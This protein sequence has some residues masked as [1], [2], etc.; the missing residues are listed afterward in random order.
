MS[1]LTR[2]DFIR[3][4]GAGAA[5]GLFGPSVLAARPGA[6]HVVILGGGIGGTTAAKYIRIM[7]PDVKIALVEQNREYITCPRSN[8]VV[9]GYLELVETFVERDVPLIGFVKN[10]AART[11]TRAVRRGEGNAPWVNDAAFFKQVLERRDDDGERRTD[12]LTFTSWFVSR[13]GA[14]RVLSA[15]GD[16]LGLDRELDPELYEVTF[17][18][19]YDPRDD[20][21]FRVEAPYAFTRDAD[22]RERIVRQALQG[23]AIER[24]PPPAI[25]R[26]DELA[27]IDREE[28]SALG[29]AIERALDTERESGYDE[30]RWGVDYLEG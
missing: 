29:G 22:L 26:A 14:D 15:A 18:V 27:R 12:A 28:K 5:L 30:S 9:A 21:L 20:L 13:D 17:C 23:I 16:A 19:V 24:G 10:P 2:R 6:P 3:L 8:D 7:N 4:F 11:I 25:A 1:R